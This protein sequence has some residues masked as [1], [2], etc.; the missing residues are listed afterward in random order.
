[1]EDQIIIALPRLA[2][3]AGSPALKQVL[4]NHLE[5]TRLQR[6]RLDGVLQRHG[7]DVRAHRDGAMQALLNEAGRWANM[8]GGND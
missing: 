6:D 8:V 7:A 2:D 5:T 4:S 3:M 1:A